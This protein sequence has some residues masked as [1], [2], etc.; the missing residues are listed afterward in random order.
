MRF[1]KADLSHSK[2]LLKALGRGKWELEG[3]EILAFSDMMRWFNGLQNKIEMELIQE[4]AQEKAKAEEAKKLAE[5]KM[6]PTPVEDVIKPID[7]QVVTVTSPEKKV[8]GKK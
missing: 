3:M 4:E 1:T 6:I 5:G 7:S 2:N 8:K